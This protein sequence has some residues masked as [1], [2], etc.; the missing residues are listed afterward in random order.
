MIASS[1]HKKSNTAMNG[2]KDHSEKNKRSVIYVKPILTF[3]QVVEI[4][5]ERIEILEQAARRMEK[6]QKNKYHNQ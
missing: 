5:D 1:L 4:I 6:K 3:D 2:K